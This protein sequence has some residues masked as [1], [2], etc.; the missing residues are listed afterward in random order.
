MCGE[1]VLKTM[2]QRQLEWLT[3]CGEVV[4]LFLPWAGLPHSKAFQNIPWSHGPRWGFE[5]QEPERPWGQVTCD[6]LGDLAVIALAC[7]SWWRTRDK[8]GVVGVIR[9]ERSKK[10]VQ[11]TSRNWKV[12]I[13]DFQHPVSS[14]FYLN[15]TIEN[16]LTTGSTGTWTRLPKE[17]HCRSKRGC[18]VRRHVHC[19]RGPGLYPSKKEGVSQRTSQVSPTL[20][21]CL[22]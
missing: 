1:H 6:S 14:S 20:S 12:G 17:G 16:P 10:Q 4:F 13:W 15:S 8:F 21:N 18:D 7:L 22:I 9:S 11:E 5:S 19:R 3:I 2:N